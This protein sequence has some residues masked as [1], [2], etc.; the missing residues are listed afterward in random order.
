M[1]K[2][3]PFTWIIL[4]INALFLIWVI[5]AISGGTNAVSDCSTLVGNAKSN[6]E[7]ENVGTAVGTGI[8]TAIIFVF[9]VIVDVILGVLWLVTRP[10]DKTRPCP[11][12]GT[13]VKKG[14]TVCPSCSYNFA[15]S[16]QPGTAGPGSV[17]PPPA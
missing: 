3:R 15:S 10:K 12:C 8:G 5:S 9:W 11:V 2:W 17:P 6:C 13:D 4:V 16:A 7:A 1:P 14:V